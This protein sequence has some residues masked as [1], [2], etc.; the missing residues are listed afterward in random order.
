LSD[1]SISM[2]EE[3]DGW[4]SSFARDTMAPA[5]VGTGT[6]GWAD[7]GALR[8]SPSLLKYLPGAGN[9]PG[10]HGSAWRDAMQ[11]K[12]FI[13]AVIAPADGTEAIE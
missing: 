3:Q 13:G 8:L 4:P 7:V 1:Y 11:F 12:V 9:Q 10:K 6:R 5:S 2:T